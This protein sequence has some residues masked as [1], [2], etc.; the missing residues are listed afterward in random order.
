[1]ISQEYIKDSLEKMADAKYRDFVSAINPYNGK[2]YGVRLPLLRKFAKEIVKE[3]NNVDFLNLPN[4]D[5]SLIH[6]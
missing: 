6:I 2:V 5:L 1:M 3:G 4:I